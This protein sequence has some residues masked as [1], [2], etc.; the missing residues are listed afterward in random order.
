MEAFEGFVLW[1]T[2]ASGSLP[3]NRVRA[4]SQAKQSGFIGKR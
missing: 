1:V 3:A 4:D 2:L